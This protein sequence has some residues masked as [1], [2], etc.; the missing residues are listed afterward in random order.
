MPRINGNLTMK[1]NYCLLFHFYLFLVLLSSHYIH[2]NLLTHQR[3]WHINVNLPSDLI[4]LINIIL[5]RFQVCNNF[6][7]FLIL[8]IVIECPEE[9]FEIITSTQAPST[10]LFQGCKDKLSDACNVD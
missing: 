1:L 8:K 4:C 6:I 2:A 10:F 5:M 7:S 3:F 9:F